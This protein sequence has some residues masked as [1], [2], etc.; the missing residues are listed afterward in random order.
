M[1]C[2]T[3]SLQNLNK[4]HKTCAGVDLKDIKANISIWATLTS[5]RYTIYIYAFSEG[6]SNYSIRLMEFMYRM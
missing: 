6:S 2:Q 4:S 1:N 5:P 3:Y